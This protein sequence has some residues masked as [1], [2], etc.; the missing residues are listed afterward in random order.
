M[1]PLRPFD[2][3]GYVAFPTLLHSFG[4]DIAMLMVGRHAKDEYKVHAMRGGVKR[5]LSRKGGLH[6]EVLLR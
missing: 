3:D 4:T 2:I 5:L 6:I 1:F